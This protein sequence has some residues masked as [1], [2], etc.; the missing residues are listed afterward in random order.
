MH[1]EIFKY[2]S[3]ISNCKSISKAAKNLYTSH[4]ALTE[5]LNQLEEEL[6]VQLFHRSKQGV[7][8]TKTGALVLAQAEVIL[9]EINKLYA[10][11]DAER[12]QDQ[13]VE[14]ISFST[15]EKFTHEPLDLTISA[16]LNRYPHTKFNIHNMS[17][18][19][20]IENIKNGTI[21]FAMIS[22]LTTEKQNVFALLQENGL[23]A[24]PLSSE[25]T[26]V[27]VSRNSA[28]AAFRSLCA[29]N[30]VEEQL[31]FHSS[32]LTSHLNENNLHLTCLPSL[33]LIL[34]MLQNNAGVTLLPQHVINTISPELMKNIAVIPFADS[35]L[36]NCIIYPQNCMFCDVASFFIKTYHRLYEEYALS[37]NRPSD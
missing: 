27:L 37:R 33:Q 11:I 28:L 18:E 5:R 15:I 21:Q 7:T 6:D 2:L 26:V 31:V 25:Q 35:E 34:Q 8:P 4:S 12:P 29:E 19:T 22:F 16:T 20:S 30:L 24:H 36:Y 9:D 1:V 13:H 32:Y 10:I 14:T 23:A 17:T 3:E